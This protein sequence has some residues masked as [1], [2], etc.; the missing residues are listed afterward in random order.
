MRMRNRPGGHTYHARAHASVYDCACPSHGVVCK[1][2]K[3]TAALGLLDW[4][5]RVSWTAPF[6]DSGPCRPP[7]R[8]TC[9]TSTTSRTRSPGEQAR[10]RLAVVASV[11]SSP[12]ALRC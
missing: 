12:R 9:A 1:R 8:V 6:D 3:Q 2:P 5:E 7:W 4:E 10:S 11:T